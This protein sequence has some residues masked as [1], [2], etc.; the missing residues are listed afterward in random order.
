MFV[1]RMRVLVVLVLLVRPGHRVAQTDSLVGAVSGSC[2]NLFS[3]CVQP[4]RVF[5]S[6]EHPPFVEHS[7]NQNGLLLLLAAHGSDFDLEN[8][9]WVCCCVDSP[10][11][12]DC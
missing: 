9:P 3:C 1:F 5:E 2:F 8:C 12:D 6:V 4:G 10:H 11:P 7:I